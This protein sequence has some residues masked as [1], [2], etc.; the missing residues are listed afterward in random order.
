M[1]AGVIVEYA[2]VYEI[3]EKSA[4]PY[5]KGLIKSVP[6]LSDSRKT[7]ETIAGDVPDPLNRPPGCKFSPRCSS[8]REE[9][10]IKTPPMVEIEPGHF[11]CCFR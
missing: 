1:Y 4:H 5:T 7:F 8:A 3:F 2:N 10:Y 9:C 6:K 11:V